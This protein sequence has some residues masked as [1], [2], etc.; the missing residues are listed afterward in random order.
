[1]ISGVDEGISGRLREENERLRDPNAYTK[2]KISRS[3]DSPVNTSQSDDEESSLVNVPTS[4]ARSTTYCAACR[5][6]ESRRWWKA[7]K[8][9]ATGILC[10]SCGLNWRKYAD[11]SARPTTREE[12]SLVNGTS[13]SASVGAKTRSAEKREGTPLAGPTA[14]RAR[15]CGFQISALWKDLIENLA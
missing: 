1:M 14:K 13:S 4:A 7:P 6:R 10:D 3:D 8:G 2:H 5:T 11:L 15:V 9:L 12:T